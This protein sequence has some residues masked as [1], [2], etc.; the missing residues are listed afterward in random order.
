MTRFAL[1]R[2][3]EKTGVRHAFVEDC[4]CGACGDFFAFGRGPGASLWIAL[5]TDGVPVAFWREGELPL[6]LAHVSEELR[7]VLRKVRDVLDVSDPA[8]GPSPLTHI[9]EPMPAALSPGLAERVIE[10]IAASKRKSRVGTRR[11][12]FRGETLLISE[13]SARTGVDRTSI[14][15]RIR[16]GWSIA[17]TLTTPV[18]KRRSA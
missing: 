6:S 10:R 2:A 9:P 12:T 13:W 16:N 5:S 7:E 18:K 4:P 17:D 1:L 15:W 11:I 3:I 8:P 14:D